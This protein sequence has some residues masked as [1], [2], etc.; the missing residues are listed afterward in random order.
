[1]RAPGCT[2]LARFQPSSREFAGMGTAW[3]TRAELGEAGLHDAI[4]ALFAMTAGFTA[5]G[6]SANL[7]RLLAKDAQSAVGRATFVA[8][9]IFAGP[10]VLFENAARA[11]RE[12]SCSGVAFWLAAAVAG[13]WSLALGL[14]V[15][16]VALALKV[17]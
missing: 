13:Y 12:K 17:Q 9:M 3:A 5:S 7:Y 4:V 15:I 10:S 2:K 11:W 16:Q 14:L 8:V 6:I 1:L